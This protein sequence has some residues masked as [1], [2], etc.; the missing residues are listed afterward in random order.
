MRRQLLTGLLMTIALTVL[1]GLAY[2]LAMTGIAQALMK[3]KANGSFV[4]GERQGRRA[5]R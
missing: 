2:P 1:V 3:D 4:L 5:R